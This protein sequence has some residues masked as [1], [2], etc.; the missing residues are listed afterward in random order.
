MATVQLPLGALPAVN[1]SEAGD[2]LSVTAVWIGPTRE[3]IVQ[4]QQIK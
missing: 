4:E 2:S 1:R 3:R